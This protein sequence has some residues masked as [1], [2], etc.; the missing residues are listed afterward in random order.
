[1]FGTNG[2]GTS[3]RY[4]YC[5]RTFTSDSPPAPVVCVTEIVAAA[6]STPATRPSSSVAYEMICGSVV[7]TRVTAASAP[8]RAAFCTPSWAANARAMSA[9]PRIVNTSSDSESAVST[10]ACPLSP[11]R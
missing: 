4:V 1:M 7:A 3:V 2:Q 11:A 10:S 8:A 9:P 6:E 5:T